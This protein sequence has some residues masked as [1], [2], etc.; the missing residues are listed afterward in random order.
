[1]EPCGQMP[2]ASL[3]ESQSR[4]RNSAESKTDRPFSAPS[5]SS[6]ASFRDSFRD[7]PGFASRDDALPQFAHRWTCN[8]AVTTVAFH[9]HFVFAG[10]VSGDLLTFDLQTYQEVHRE[11]AHSSSI[12]TLVCSGGLLFSGSADS[13]VKVWLPGPVPDFR[14]TVYTLTDIGDIFSL[15]YWPS[16]SLLYIG[17]QNA[18]LHWVRLDDEGLRTGRCRKKTNMPA[19]RPSRFFDSQGPGGK[20]APQQHEARKMAA[21]CSSDSGLELVEV[22]MDNTIAFAHYS[23]I[24]AMVLDTRREIVVT[25]SGD[26]VVKIWKLV[27]GSPVLSQELQ[28]GNSVFSMAL[29]SSWQLCCGLDTNSII[30]VDLDTLQLLRHELPPADAP[31]LALAATEDGIFASSGNRLLALDSASAEL[32]VWPSP[33]DVTAIITLPREFTAGH[34]VSAGSDGSVVLWNV[35]I[36]EDELADSVSS[37]SLASGIGRLKIEPLGNDA[38]VQFLSKLV[39]C[40]TV[41]GRDRQ[42][43]SD[44]RRCATLLRDQMRLMGANAELV[45]VEDGNPIVFGEFK[46]NAPSGPPAPS[47]PGRILFYGHYDVIEAQRDD[48]KWDVPP[49]QLTSINGY[50][51]GRGVTDDK[52]PCTAALFAVAR[53]HAE[54][55]LSSD[56]VFLIEGEE[57]SGSFGFLE[58]AAKIQ[59]KI[60]SIDWIVFS[61]SLWLNE[62]R[63]CLN[64][65]L[66]GVIFVEIEVTSGKGDMHSGVDGGLYREPAKDMINL[67]AKLTDE[68]TG[69]ITIPSFADH[70]LPLTDSEK[71]LYDDIVAATGTAREDLIHKWRLPSLTVHK[72]EVSGPHNQTV[73]PANVKAYI[74]L[75][76]VP[77]QTAEGITD[78]LQRY[79]D[80]EFA[81]FD[82]PN[83]LRTRVKYEADPWLGNPDNALFTLMRDSVEKVWGEAPLFI[84]EGGSIPVAR[85]LEKMFDAPAAQLPCGQSSD[86]AHLNNERMRA[87]NMFNARSVF[88][89]V[90]EK[91]GR[92]Q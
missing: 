57:E 24:F 3:I 38:M 26:G 71:Q 7:S 85:A 39:R 42:H 10:T 27:K 47:A 18:S 90:F 51:Y 14:H 87:T 91:L 86:G 81:Q 29:A 92:R 62:H 44:S 74:S 78:K 84:R 22:P 8:E 66:R 31:L 73:I 61:N 16:Q 50:L 59:D 60:G 46:R 1:M 76:L 53:L 5:S 41:S 83:Q 56:V 70:V 37:S 69:Q 34:L 36:Y 4:R 20:L 30:L 28:V 55:R 40:Q 48:V 49:F 65:G 33:G 79:L 25:G 72:F 11:H 89:E 63:P 15:A 52:G 19:V 58:T 23:A 32:C 77:T 75:R 43:W 68:R 6:R 67:L 80:S 54:R 82:S 17:T 64:Y 35:A 88:E 2:L 45:R 12:L 13:L 21:S 9:D